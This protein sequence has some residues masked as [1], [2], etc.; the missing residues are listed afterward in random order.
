MLYYYKRDDNTQ[1]IEFLKVHDRGIFMSNIDFTRKL[2]IGIQ[3]FE[4][5]RKGSYLYVD[6]TACILGGQKGAF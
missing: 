6:K 4:K 2:P 3:D 5:I 1:E